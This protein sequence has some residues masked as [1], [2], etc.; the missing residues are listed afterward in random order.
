MS[1]LGTCKVQ[2]LQQLSLALFNLGRPWRSVP[3]SQWKSLTLI[4]MLHFTCANPMYTLHINYIK[5]NFIFVEPVW[6]C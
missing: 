2:R 6:R 3:L 5:N 4:Q 1:A